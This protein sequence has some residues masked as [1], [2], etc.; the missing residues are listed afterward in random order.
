MIKE[1]KY[2]FSPIFPGQTQIVFCGDIIGEKSLVLG[3]VAVV[4]G[5]SII[6]ESLRPNGSE[7]EAVV[8]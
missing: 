4:G 1:D 6:V 5:P 8:Y 7:S 2:E 3:R